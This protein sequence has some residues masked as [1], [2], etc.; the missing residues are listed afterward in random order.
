MEKMYIPILKKKVNLMCG[1]LN[2]NI[3]VTFGERKKF[4]SLSIYIGISHE[5]DKTAQPTMSNLKSAF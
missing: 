5:K 2:Y 3:I 4:L 1:L